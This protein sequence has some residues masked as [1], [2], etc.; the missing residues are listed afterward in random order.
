MFVG[1]LECSTNT[2][3]CPLGQLKEERGCDLVKVRLC[4]KR[5]KQLWVN[6]RLLHVFHIPLDFAYHV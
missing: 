4:E 1:G 3:N 6:R 5:L 2:Q